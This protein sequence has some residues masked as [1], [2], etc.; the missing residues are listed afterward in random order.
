M[1]LLMIGY[2]FYFLPLML[3]H[4]LG[5][6]GLRFHFQSHSTGRSQVLFATFELCY[7]FVACRQ[8]LCFCS[9]VPL[10]LC[11]LELVPA[12][13]P[14]NTGVLKG[15]EFSRQLCDARLVLTMLVSH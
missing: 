15:Q 6:R 13:R 10:V 7:V 8:P 3:V 11:S 1:K 14:L 2:G 4:C 12:Y 9:C 5:F